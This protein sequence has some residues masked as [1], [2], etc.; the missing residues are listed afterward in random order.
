MYDIFGHQNTKFQ[1]TILIIF[2]KIFRKELFIVILIPRVSFQ[3]MLT[4][5]DRRPAI[6]K[7]FVTQLPIKIFSKKHSETVFTKTAFQNLF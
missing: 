1:Y 7:R 5:S 4:Y 6:F 2:V 3:W